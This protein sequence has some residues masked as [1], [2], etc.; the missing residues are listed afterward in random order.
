MP[1]PTDGRR[2]FPFPPEPRRRTGRAVGPRLRA[3]LWVAVAVLVPLLANSLYLVGVRAADAARAAGYASF[4]PL[5]WF[6]PWMLLGHVALGLLATA[7]LVAFGVVHM[8]TARGRANRRAVR[9]GYATFA[10]ALGLLVT[11]FLLCRVEGVIDLA[12][13]LGRAVVY[14]LHV[15]LPVAC[16]VLYWRHRAVGRRVNWRAG[17]RL[18]AGTLGLAGV[19]GGVHLLDP[20]GA[21]ADG[22]ATGAA[23][24]APSLA[25]TADG[26]FVPAARLSNDAACAECHTDAHAAHMTSAHRFSSFN[27]PLYLASVRAT[28]ATLLARTGSDEAVKWCAG[29][30]DPVPLLSGRLDD[31]FFDDRTDPAAEAGIT[32]TVCHAISEVGAH[33]G[34]RGN[35]DFTLTAPQPYPFEGRREPLLKWI[36]R[37]LVRA[38]PAV[39]KRDMLKPLHKSAE[40]CA[41][42]HKVGLPPEVNGH[43]WLRGQNH[44]DGFR[45]SGVRGTSAGAFYFPPKAE[46][47]CNGCHMP[48]VPS[49]DFGAAP[50]ADDSSSPA[51]E[52]PAFET[53]A[54]E[55]PAFETLSIHDHRFLGANTAL[56]WLRGDAESV[57]AHARFLKDCVRVDLFGVRAGGVLDGELTAPLRPTVPTLAPGETVLLETVVRTLTLGHPFTQG[58]AD[59]NEVWLELTVSTGDGSAGETLLTSGAIDPVTGAVDPR[60]HFFDAFVVDRD[61]NRIARR[62]AEDIFATL[63]SH[64]IPP[65]AAALIHHRLTVPA[66]AAGPVTVSARVRYRKFR[67]DYLRFAAAAARPGDAPLRADA[68][69]PPVVTLASDSVTFP[70]AGSSAAS[71]AEVVNPP[72]DVPAWERWN[73]AGI[74]SLLKGTAELRQAAE[75]FARVEALGRY[76]GPLNLA[77]VHL[78]EGRPELAAAALDRAAARDAPAA[79]PW[80]VRLLSGHV[81]RETGDL[82]AAAVDYRE[83]LRW[84]R[85]P[86]PAMAARGF[87]FAGDDAA[88]LALGRTYHDLARRERDPGRASERTRLLRMAVECFERVLAADDEHVAALDNLAR[89]HRELDEPVRAA[90][91]RARHAVHRP[92]DAA[93]SEAL[94]RARVRYPHA[95]A[96]AETVTVYDFRPAAATDATK[97]RPPGRVSV[98]P[99]RSDPDAP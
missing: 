29:C 40:F 24:F 6:V 98:R 69:A 18:A 23:P 79:P 74:G 70:V 68:D 60:A 42:C 55:T 73:D 67:P 90:A 85:P 10:A 46:A 92:D 77:R 84:D 86:T 89:L 93:A 88:A 1:R 63:Y 36:N 51:F 12:H 66:D 27:N 4:D 87:D 52:T 32:C 47:N 50:H 64:Q 5:N 65:G 83:V 41:T 43:R 80:T 31:P 9:A 28:R 33:G 3:V 75:C 44:Y 25:D 76:D 59:S 53:P 58:T 13:P 95:A 22:R 56:P 49:D 30:H 19:L 39:H 62:N 35:A 14:G 71:H 99:A 17:R 45:L 21:A 97:P 20:H 7:P 11:G 91:Y 72:R 38:K 16:G 8:V 26:R 78:A 61:G 54:F 94:R 34:A 2:A 57:R 96:A 37:Q 82:D 81:R 48:R 15:G